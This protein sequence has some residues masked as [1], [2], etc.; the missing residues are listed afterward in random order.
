MMPRLEASLTFSRS[1]QIQSIFSVEPLT[2][3]ELDHQAVNVKRG[4]EDQSYAENMASS[5][6]H[7]VL[8]VNWTI[9]V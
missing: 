6:K 9:K 7:K 8:G 4:A 1:S 2:G 3:K 5:H